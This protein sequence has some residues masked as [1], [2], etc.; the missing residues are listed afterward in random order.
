MPTLKSVIRTIKTQIT[1]WFGGNGRNLR[2]SGNPA[3]AG[4]EKLNALL[5]APAYDLVTEVMAPWLQELAMEHGDCL[6]GDQ[7]CRDQVQKTIESKPS[8]VAIFCGH[9]SPDA[10]LGSPKPP[11]VLTFKGS[12]HSA[13]YD[14]AMV[15]TGPQSLFAFCCNAGG[16][17]GSL[18]ASFEGRSFLGYLDELPYDFANTECKKA[19]KIVV[20]RVAKQIIHDGGIGREHH[21]LLRETYNEVMRDFRNGT[22]RKNPHAG[23]MQMCLLR[24]MKLLCYYGV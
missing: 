13:I 2:G 1:V 17:L 9:G 7:L 4:N 5:W 15:A 22:L 6:F 21:Q 8:R 12:A 14:C 24:H 16:Q 20:Q 11:N 18:F 10:L 3:I 23:W 19:W